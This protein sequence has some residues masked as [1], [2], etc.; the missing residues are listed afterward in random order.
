M[1]GELSWITGGRFPILVS[2][3][4]CKLLRSSSSLSVKLKPNQTSFWCPWTSKRQDFNLSKHIDKKFYSRCVKVV[5][6]HF[7]DIANTRFWRHKLRIATLK[8]A[9]KTQRVHT[10]FNYYMDYKGGNLMVFVRLQPTCLGEN[11]QWWK[12]CKPPAYWCCRVEPPFSAW[13][14]PL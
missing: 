6:Y 2:V 5:R 1:S 9:S 7:F 3:N 8:P 11:V 14:F 13:L 12:R 4:R 10:E